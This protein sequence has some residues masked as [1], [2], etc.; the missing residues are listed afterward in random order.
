MAANVR[1]VN[2]I[3]RTSSSTIS[4][5]VNDF[6]KMGNS[7][8]D[9][10]RTERTTQSAS[11]LKS[12]VCND[13]SD[14]NCVCRPDTSQSD[15]AVVNDEIQES[16]KWIGA[17]KFRTKSTRIFDG[18]LQSRGSNLQR[19]SLSDDSGEVQSGRR[20]YAA[21]AAASAK[22]QHGHAPIVASGG[23]KR[24]TNMA[25]DVNGIT[26]SCLSKSLGLET[27]SFIPRGEHADSERDWKTLNDMDIIE[28]VMQQHL[29]FTSI[30]KS[31]VTKLQ[32]IRRFWEGTNLKGALEAMGKM[33]DH[34][35][36]VDVVSVLIERTEVFTLEICAVILPLLTNLLGSEIERYL[37]VALGTLLV[38]VRSFG[39]VICSTRLASPSLGVDIQADERRERC[40]ICYKELEKVKR[41]LAPLIRRSGPVAQSAQ[42]LSVTL[43]EV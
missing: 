10:D 39:H 4:S 28:A 22:F 35:V 2:N 5:K 24:E 7:T 8:N 18:D 26:D 25:I 20:V 23:A 12:T 19:S 21:E 16:F 40:K 27:S 38:L 43:Q 42:E 15:S 9:S 37:N 3:R 29:T 34:S 13:R 17:A 36:L 14:E 1:E 6:I 11:I 31:R 32:A 41:S 30:M 33:G